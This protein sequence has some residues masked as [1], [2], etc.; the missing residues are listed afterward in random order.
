MNVLESERRN[1][2]VLLGCGRNEKNGMFSG[3]SKAEKQ[4]LRHCNS[5]ASAIK[6]LKTVGAAERL[7]KRST[8]LISSTF[9][10]VYNSRNQSVSLRDQN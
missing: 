4:I 8:N 6:S 9:C 10:R 1:K 3:Q 2:N 7:S 5:I